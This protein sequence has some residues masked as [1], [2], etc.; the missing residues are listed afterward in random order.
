MFNEEFVVIPRL[1]LNDNR[2][3]KTDCILFGLLKSLSLKEGYCFCTN[4]YL[5]EYINTTVR[6]VNYSLSKLKKY[7]YIIIYLKKGRRKIYIKGNEILNYVSY[8]NEDE[9]IPY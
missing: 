5:A 2:L 4:E 8:I 1:L 7:G 3:S 6:N 9:F